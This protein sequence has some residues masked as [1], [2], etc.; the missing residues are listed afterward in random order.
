MSSSAKAQID[1]VVNLYKKVFLIPSLASARISPA[2][3]NTI[4]VSCAL[5][6]PVLETNS[7]VKLALEFAFNSELQRIFE[8][9][10]LN[11]SGL[12]TAHSEDG[13]LKAVLEDVPKDGKSRQFIKILSGPRILKTYDLSAHDVHGD[14]YTD[15][16]FGAFHFSPD[17]KKLLYV[18]EKKLPKCESFYKQKPKP[19]KPKSK[20]EEEESSR[21]TEYVYKPDWGEQL[22]GKHLSVVVILNT[23]DDSITPLTTIPDDCFPSQVLW[24]PNGEDIFGVAYTLNK[25]R[26]GLY[27][28]TNREA[29]I[30]HLKGSEFNRITAKGLYCTSPRMSPDKK[31]LIWLEREVGPAHNNVKRL[32]C[33]KLNGA[34]EPDV[35]VDLVK[36]N[37]IIAN[38]KKFYGLYNGALPKRCWSDDSKYIFLST[39]QRSTVKSYIVNLETKGMTEIESSDGSSL[40]IADVKLGVVAFH[41]MSLIQPSQLLIGKFESTG[42]SIEKFVQV[43]TTDES[44]GENNLTYE[45]NE[46]VYDTDEPVKEFNFTYFGKKDAPAQSMPLLAVA[47]GGPHGSYS[48]LFLESYALFALLGFGI[49][50][51]NYRGSTGMGGDNVEYLLGKVGEVDV[52]DCMT[53]I[54]MTL[55]KYPWL[56]PKR[57]S[58]FGGSHGGFLGAQLTGQYPDRFNAAVLLNP[59]IDIVGMYTSTDIPDWSRAESG[60]PFLEKIPYDASDDDYYKILEKMMKHS[61]IVHVK[62]VKAPTLLQLGSKDLRVPMSQGKLWYH[63]LITNNVVA[64][65]A[66]YEDNHS[67]R[68]DEVALDSVINSALWLL[69]H[70]G[71][72]LE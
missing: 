37:V 19:K 30:F 64:K 2:N 24:A 67:L 45:H 56:D 63:N 71:I 40:M 46:Y 53:A 18:A 17:N 13:K 16:T 3:D 49:V 7:K 48:N 59:V 11:V 6:Q 31:N 57:V 69:E 55:Q 54:D 35:L 9:S 4:R 42:P 61:P 14:V 23:E 10:V 29:C 21:G 32:M 43:L 65:L 47:H 34:N 66:V 33:L 22:V 50:H 28:C 41:K 68:K 1:K 62:K 72:T 12:L 15:A 58:V 26:L 70:N 51:I 25:I 20:D 60:L 39:P 27:A 52:R 38:N 8:S 44:F 36:T 5:S